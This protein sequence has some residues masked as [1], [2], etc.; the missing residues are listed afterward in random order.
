MSHEHHALIFGATGNIGGATA[1]E[2]LRRG[3]KVRAVTRN[4]GGEEAIALAELGAE[5][6]QAD[7]EDR[8]SV[9]TAMSGMKRV[10]S[11]Q[12][13]TKSG[14]DGEIR[15]GKLVAESAHAAGVEH[16]IYISAGTGEAETGIP[17]FNSKLEVEAHIRKLDLPYTI[18]RPG[19][20][21][22]LMTKKEF[23]P[24]LAIWGAAPKILGWNTPKPW[25]AVRD[26]GIAA[27]NAFS[28]PD[29]WIG[30]EINYY[31][32]IRSLADCQA[33]YR[34]AH[35]RKPARIPLP[36]WLFRRLAGEEFILMWDWIGNKARHGN[37]QE[38][39]RDLTFAR[40]L[41]ADTLSVEDFFKVQSSEVT[42][43]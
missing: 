25:V 37:L 1:R 21:M 28:D 8:R 24:A 13:W 6:V 40:T 11:V 7:M 15:Q 33:A 43:S 16:F 10:L 34:A 22:E 26:L 38:L 27:A 12:S 41:H 29:A 17:H 31:S 42:S 4:P 18:I 30:Y 2:L 9:D 39:E 35:G 5:V 14:V 36:R 20:F 19:P 23:F 32:H 3:W